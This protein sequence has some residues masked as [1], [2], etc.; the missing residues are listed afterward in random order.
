MDW[1]EAMGK[2]TRHL[3][4]LHG[5]AASSLAKQMRL[6]GIGWDGSRVA[7]WERGE[8]PPTIPTLYTLLGS[9]SELAGEPVGLY[10]ILDPNS[11]ASLTDKLTV[12]G[13]NVRAMLAGGIVRVEAPAPDLEDVRNYP[14]WTP[15][16]DKLARA[17][18]L[19]PLDTRYL[20]HVK[21][22]HSPSAERDRRAAPG[23]SPQARGRVMRSIQAEMQEAVDDMRESGD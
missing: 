20:A 14:D 12:S 1:V 9:L 13:E 15:A 4:E 10:D 8:I 23:A 17:L 21:Y 11:T 3:R 5:I 22:G 7:A 2:N 6:R 16:D 18:G 19:T